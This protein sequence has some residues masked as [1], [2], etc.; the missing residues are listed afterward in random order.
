MKRIFAIRNLAL[1]IIVASILMPLSS[2]IEKK[3]SLFSED[4]SSFY[5]TYSKKEII[6]ESSPKKYVEHFF[7]KG[8]EYF[9]SLDSVLFF[10][11]VRDTTLN[12]SRNGIDYKIIIEKKKMGHIRLQVI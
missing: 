4:K 7:L 11:V 1:S 2:C 3:K 8:G 6:I 9:D 5:I 12:I 10:S